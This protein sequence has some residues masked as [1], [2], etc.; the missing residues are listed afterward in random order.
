MKLSVPRIAQTLGFE[1][2]INLGAP[3]VQP[4]SLSGCWMKLL[5]ASNYSARAS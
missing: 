3:G 4:T 1:M 2:D 5:V